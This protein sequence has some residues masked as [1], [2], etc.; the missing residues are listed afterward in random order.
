MRAIA[1]AARRRAFYAYYQVRPYL[2]VSIRKHLQRLW[3]RGWK[4]LTFPQWPVDRTVDRILER[5]LVLSMTAHGIDHIP[6]IWFWPDGK[7]SCAILTHDVEEMIGVNF[8][9]SLMEIDD[10]FGVKSSFQF[11]PETRY[12]VSPFLLNRIRESGFEI[13]LHDLNHDGRLYD[14]RE[15]FLRRA[16]RINQYAKRYGAAGFRAGALYR[17][18]DWYDAYEFSYDMS[19]PNVAHLDPQPGGCCTVMPYFIGNVLELPL[20]TIQ[21]YTL[22]YILSVHSIDLWQQQIELITESHGLASFNVHPDYMLDRRAKDTYKSLLAHLSELRSGGK[23][24]M[25]LPREV[26][27]WW[28]D[29]SQMKIVGESGRWRIEGPGR[30]RA[31]LAYARLVGDRLSYTFE[32]SRE[33][34]QSVPAPSGRKLEGPA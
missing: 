31:K 11:I 32:L 30:E 12:S 34:M 5:L 16:S 33:R 1:S 3:L 20:T 21:D 6:F 22:L 28:R 13:N 29:R 2:G 4:G 15:E 19:V 23:L 14:D 9:P 8:C 26:D 18:L 24:W 10:S 25:P 17:N 7:E 27:R